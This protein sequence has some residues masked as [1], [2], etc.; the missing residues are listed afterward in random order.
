VTLLLKLVLVPGLI[1]LVTLAGRR[2]GA[3]I[4]GW[5]NALPLV[6]G[7]VLFFLALEQGEAFVARAALATLTGLAAVAAF[8]VVYAWTATRRPW[9]VCVAVGWAAFAALTVALQAT[10]WSAVSGLALALS[11]FGLARFLL[12]GAPDAPIPPP[13]PR[14]DLPLRMAAAV[15]LVLVITGLAGWLGPRLSGALT[16]FPI[17]TTILLAFTHAQQGAPAAVSFL[18]AFLPAMW[19]FAL[20]CFVL[21][22]GVV[23]LGRDRAFLGALVV[24]MVVQGAVWLGLRAAASRGSARAGPRA[25]R[26]SA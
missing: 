10:S 6:A 19:S 1:A 4:G 23:E 20:F 16:P 18:R 14:W 3:R 13:A 5:L 12:P 22:C 24:Q 2:F 11:G 25:A 26:R 17:A 21:A 9:W 8:A 15:V 7:P